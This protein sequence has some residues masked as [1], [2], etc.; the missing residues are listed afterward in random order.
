MTTSNYI[1]T[2]A[3]N[4]HDMHVQHKGDGKP[5][6]MILDHG[7]HQGDRRFIVSAPSGLIVS[8]HGEFADAYNAMAEHDVWS[9][10]VE[11]EWEAEAQA[12]YVKG[13]RA[14]K[15]VNHPTLDV[16]EK[17]YIARN[18]EMHL[19][20][21][22]KGWEDYA[23]DLPCVPAEH[24]VPSM[25][26]LKPELEAYAEKLRATGEFT[27]YRHVRQPYDTDASW[28]RALNT[29]ATYFHYSRVVD[30]QVCV[31]YVQMGDYPTLGQ[32]IEHSM[33]LTPSRL[34]GSAARVGAK[35]GDADTLGMDGLPADSVEMAR[36]VARPYN[37]CP[38]NAEPT[39][40]AKARAQGG[41]SMPKK[42]YRG[43]TL[44]NGGVA[45]IGKLYAA[46]M[47]R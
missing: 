38:Y 41:Q 21:W 16:A 17:R 9:R 35:W 12:A 31:G 27:V 14:S 42:Y 24:K 46:E 30:G 45:A 37:W 10:K 18:G 36:I 19:N 3:P 43:A 26:P 5:A 32:P 23:L 7:Q 11:A 29:P 22:L 40:E 6:G 28:K 4:G 8:Y 1:V 47:A 34:N 25:Q 2:T 33:P 15:R 39:T 20:A 13:Y 44:P